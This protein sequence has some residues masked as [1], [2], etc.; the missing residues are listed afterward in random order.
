ME[1]E[2][3]N[4]LTIV[5]YYKDGTMGVLTLPIDK[6]WVNFNTAIKEEV[7]IWYGENQY[8][9]CETGT[10]GFE[11]FYNGYITKSIKFSDFGKSLRDVLKPCSFSQDNIFSPTPD[12]K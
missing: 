11:F 4:I 9:F 10:K 12:D 3:N 8:V 2:K 7:H 6:N 1:K 5:T